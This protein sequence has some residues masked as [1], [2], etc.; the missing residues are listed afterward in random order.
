MAI[1]SQWIMA[2]SKLHIYGTNYVHICICYVFM[3]VY[4]CFSLFYMMHLYCTLYFKVAEYMEIKLWKYKH[5][6]FKK[7]AQISVHSTRN[8]GTRHQVI[9]AEFKFIKLIIR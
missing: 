9:L 6:R 4:T 3:Y 5:K 7:G 2:R 8:C 1:G